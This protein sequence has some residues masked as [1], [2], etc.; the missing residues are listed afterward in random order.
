MVVA[1]KSH[2]NVSLLPAEIAHVVR[3]LGHPEGE[4]GVIVELLK[5]RTQ[6]IESITEGHKA[7]V[8]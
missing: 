6:V 7:R 2:D 1:G 3:D 8:S 5:A 4:L